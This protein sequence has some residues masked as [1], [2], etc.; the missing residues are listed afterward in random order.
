M[1]NDERVNTIR[2]VI[3]KQPAPTGDD[4]IM[5]K[6]QTCGVLFRERKISQQ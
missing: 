6:N 3:L 4:K 1:L 2:F 5:N